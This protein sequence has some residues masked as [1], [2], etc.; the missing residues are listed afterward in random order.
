MSIALVAFLALVPQEHNS[1]TELEKA[2]GWKLLFDGSST[3]GWHN[4][5][6]SSVGSGWKVEGGQLIIADPRNA[7][8]IVTD[9][10][11]TWFELSLEASLDPGQNSGIMVRVADG[12]KAPWHSGPE[13]QL[14]DHAPEK[15]V[16]VT[17]YLYQLYTAEHHAAKPSGEWNQIRILWSKEKCATWVNGTKYYEFV[18]RSEDFLARVAKSKFTQFPEFAKAEKGRIG[19]QGDHGKVAFRNIK[20]RPI[21]D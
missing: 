18:Y 8:D 5:N 10:M 19:I 16:E 4:Y 21:E 12:S 3:Q 6:E 7:G 1:L 11:F 14:Y 17:G 2:S 15:G 9:E 20:I 13:I